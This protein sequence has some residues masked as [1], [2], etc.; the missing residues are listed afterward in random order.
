VP[1][2][3]LLAKVKHKDYDADLWRTCHALYAGGKALLGDRELLTELLPS[4]NAEEQWVYDERC[5]RAF[6]IP[7]AGQVID[8]IVASLFGQKVTIGLEGE[9]KPDR[10]WATWF[11]NLSRPGGTTSSL[12][13]LLREQVKTALIKG[14]AWTL[15]DM[16]RPTAEGMP[17][18][19]K[20][21]EDSGLDRP[22]AV[23]IDPECVVRWR[24]D[25]SG[26]LEWALIRSV[27]SQQRDLE[28]D[29]TKVRESYVYWTRRDWTRFEVEYDSDNPP[30]DTDEI[31]RVDGGKHTAGRVPL[32]RLDLPEALWAMGKLWPLARE[33]L[34]KANSLSWQE[35]KSAFQFL[36][37]Y[38]A[39]PDPGSGDATTEDPNRAVNQ[40]IGQGRVMTLSRDDKLEYVGPDVS[41]LADMRAGC[42]TL[43]DEMFRVVHHMSLAIDNSASA[44]GRSAE[45]KGADQAPASVV[46]TTLGFI[47]RKHAQRIVERAAQARGDSPLKWVAKGMEKF[48]DVSVAALVTQEAVVETIPIPSQTFQVER[49]VNLARRLLGDAATDE[50]L[51][52]VRAELTESMNTESLIA[53]MNARNGVMQ[54][55]ES[56]DDSPSLAKRRRRKVVADD[57]TFGEGE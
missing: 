20:E 56:E 38:L 8:F 22:Y 51:A 5:A 25:E 15:V 21:E 48:D 47:V 26:E 12:N 36:V 35:Y 52:R 43:R 19:L 33:H 4:H 11:E 10:F 9:T 28:D 24:E 29:G 39:P 27:D 17:T 14:R 49:L 18:S 53:S 50:T 41:G 31:K 40:R 1:Q 46:L 54:D 32:E 42:V 16:P 44:L 34:N 23:A 57:E 37:A 45:S 13:E 7:Y 6:Y 3:K 2:Y 55:Q 30:S